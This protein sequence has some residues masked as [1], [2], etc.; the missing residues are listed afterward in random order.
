MTNSRKIDKALRDSVDRPAFFDGSGTLGY[1]C[2][3]TRISVLDY[4]AAQALT[5]LVFETRV[6]DDGV[7]DEA[8]RLAIAMVK[9]RQELIDELYK[10]D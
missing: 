8:Y 3:G 1:G 7:A 2:N 5:G 9:R 10:D 6:S 4:F